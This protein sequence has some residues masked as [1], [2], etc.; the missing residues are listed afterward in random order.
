MRLAFIVP[1]A[2]VK[3]FARYNSIELAEAQICYDNKDYF[4]YFVQRQKDGAHVILD[5]SPRI[6]QDITIEEYLEL[7]YVMKPAEI[8]ATDIARE[9]LQSVQETIHFM[10]L[11]EKFGIRSKGIKIMGV[12]QGRSFEEWVLMYQSLDR[13]IGVDSI[14]FPRPLDDFEG[15]EFPSSWFE[16]AF[17]R[18]KVTRARKMAMARVGLIQALDKKKVINRFRPHHLL[19]LTDGIELKWQ[20]INGFLRSNDSSSAFYHGAQG[21]RYTSAGLPV[22]KKWANLDFTMRGL[23]PPKLQAVEHNMKMLTGF[24]NL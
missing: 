10:D 22:E 20:K 13:L 3:K 23:D 24:A 1:T 21:I 18:N 16:R 5:N 4:E 7:A 12:I 6:K 9:S 11:A 19:G 14:G 2:Y 15:F 17:R 8:I